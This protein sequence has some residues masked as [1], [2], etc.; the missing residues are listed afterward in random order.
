LQSADFAGA[1]GCFTAALG[2]ARRWAYPR[3]NLALA[4]AESGE[5]LEAER[6]YR[7]AIRNTPYYPYLYINLAVLLQKVGRRRDAAREYENVLTVFRN[8]EAELRR[9]AGAWRTSGNPAEAADAEARA[10]LLR[11]NISE[12]YNGLGTISHTERR[13]QAAAALYERAL[14]EMTQATVVTEDDLVPPRHNLASLYENT[15]TNPDRA[16]ELWEANLKSDPEFLPSRLALAKAY[17]RRR[18]PA[19]AEQNYRLALQ[20]AP[21][22]VDAVE[23]LA[24]ALEGLGR[25]DDARAVLET[26]IFRQ[27]YPSAALLDL[28]GDIERAQNQETAACRQF[29]AAQA[30]L[31]GIPGRNKALRDKLR[32]CKVTGSPDKASK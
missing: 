26:G 14:L 24:R 20:Q 16:I 4:Y 27:S 1:I 2:Q 31:R 3:V 25:L 17:L 11:R 21:G 10:N 23:G 8:Q 9:R 6:Q 5:Y 22:N 12:A 18:R 30:A 13:F 32:A 19:E 28:L 29:A 15:G 7:E